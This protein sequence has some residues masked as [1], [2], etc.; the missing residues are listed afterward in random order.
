[1]RFT[2]SAKNSNLDALKQD[3][4]EAVANVLN[5]PRMYVTMSQMKE[6]KNLQTRSDD[7]TVMAEIAYKNE[8]DLK[9]LKN[10][11]DSGKFLTDFNKEVKRIVSLNDKGVILANIAAIGNEYMLTLFSVT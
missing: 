2:H 1:M 5:V 4:V 7:F 10:V 3:L 6:V 11:I 9:N 8:K